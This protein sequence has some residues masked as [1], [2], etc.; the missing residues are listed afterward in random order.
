[1]VVR[2]RRIR[3]VLFSLAAYAMAGGLVAYFGVV[4]A[5]LRIARVPLRR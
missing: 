5:I 2:R 1:M 3:V 4:L